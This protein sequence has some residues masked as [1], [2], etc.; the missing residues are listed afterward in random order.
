MVITT[1]SINDYEELKQ[2]WINTPGMGM[3]EMDD[4]KEGI[5]KYLSRNPRTCF[6]ARDEE[7]LI[8]GILSGHDGRR[9]YIYHTAVA[10]SAREK[11][12]GTALLERA[13]HALKEEGIT[14]VALLAYIDNE[15]G[16]SFW[17]GKGFLSRKDVLY[18]NKDI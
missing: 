3:N 10:E 14:K 15:I 18:R 17:K 16:N 1:M 7:Q 8:G 4:S 5:A 12:V 2:L 6:V 9:G 11:G 13:L